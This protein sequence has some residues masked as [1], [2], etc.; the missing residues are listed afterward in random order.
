[1]VGLNNFWV[2]PADVRGSTMEIPKEPY[3]SI[4]PCTH[5]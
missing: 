1:M 5:T 4:I 3:L 2:S